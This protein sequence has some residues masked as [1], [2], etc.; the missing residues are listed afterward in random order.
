[1]EAPWSNCI[2][3]KAPQCDFHAPS[4]LICDLN[5]SPPREGN[6]PSVIDSWQF[7][8]ETADKLKE[9]N[10]QLSETIKDAPAESLARE[11]NRQGDT[12]PSAEEA[13]QNHVHLK[14]PKRKKHRPKVIVEGKSKRAK[15]T[16]AQEKAHVKESTVAKR[17]HVR[18]KGPKESATE[19]ADDAGKTSDLQN[20]AGTKSRRRALNFDLEQNVKSNATAEQEK[21][22]S[23]YLQFSSSAHA[24]TSENLTAASLIHGAT[25]TPQTHQEE[26]SDIQ[27]HPVAGQVDAPRA[28]PRPAQALPALDMVE[29]EF[30][31]VGRKDKQ[32][33]DWRGRER[34]DPLRVNSLSDLINRNVPALHTKQE[35]RQVNL[36]GEKYLNGISRYQQAL[37][38]AP[39]NFP[40]NLQARGLKRCYDQNNE[41]AFPPSQS[42]MGIPSVQQ[43][44]QITSYH[45]NNRS[46]GSECSNAMIKKNKTKKGLDT[47]TDDIPSR[48]ARVDDSSRQEIARLSYPVETRMPLPT[49]DV[50]NVSALDSIYRRVR[51]RFNSCSP[52]SYFSSNFASNKSESAASAQQQAYLQW[53]EVARRSLDVSTV[54]FAAVQTRKIQVTSGNS[55]SSR[56]KEK[57]KGQQKSLS[58]EASGPQKGSSSQMKDWNPLDQIIHQLGHLNL[59]GEGSGPE[60]NALVL[61]KEYGTI[62]PYEGLD[63]R[64]RKPRPKVDLDSETKR[65][66]N[67]L[68]GKESEGPQHDVEKEKWW[69]E[70]REVF[71]GRADSFIARMH[72]IQGDRRFSRWKGSVVDSVIGVFLTQNVSDHLSSSAFMSLIAR[73]PPGSKRNSQTPEKLNADLLIKEPV[74]HMLNPEGTLVLQDN[75]EQISSK[76]FLESWNARESAGMEKGQ[77]HSSEEEMM[78]SLESF[79]CSIT[80]GYGGVRSFSGSNSESEDIANHLKPEETCSLLGASLQK[81]KFMYGHEQSNC[82]K[83]D[84]QGLILGRVK[85]TSRYSWNSSP[86][87]SGNHAVPLSPSL[88]IESLMQLKESNVPRVQ[89]NI[90]GDESMSSW[91]TMSQS[92]DAE[93]QSKAP[94]GQGVLPGSKGKQ[95]MTD[96]QT[97]FDATICPHSSILG[98]APAISQSSLIQHFHEHENS[99]SQETSCSRNA[100]GFL[101]PIAREPDSRH[102]VSSTL[103]KRVNGCKV[104]EVDRLSHSQDTPVETNAAEGLSSLE[105]SKEIQTPAKAKRGKAVE[106]RKIDWDYLRREVQVNCEKR[107]RTKDS[108]DS[109]DY[110]ALRQ[111]SINEISD[112]IRE[113]GMNNMLAERIKG[114]LDRLVQEHGSID[115]EWLRDVSP[116]K[117]KDYLLSIRGLGLKSVECVRLLTLHN[118]AFPVDTN[119]GRIAVRLGWVPLQP[120]P[121]S[122]QL[123]LLELYPVLES[124]QKYLWP[125]LCKLD[126]P[127][128]YELHYQLITFG[129]VFCTKSRP[130]C[131]GCPMRGE[132]RHF[133]SAFTSARLALPAPEDKSLVP[134]MATPGENASSTVAT[135]MLLPPAQNQSYNTLSVTNDCQP[136]I[137]EPATPE[138]ERAV[139][140]DR[141]IEDLFVEDDDEIPTIKLNIKEFTDNLQSFMQQNNMELQE[142]DMSKALVA[143]NPEAASIPARKLKNVSRLRTEHQVYEL[144]DD[145]PLLDGLEKREEDDPSPYLLAIWTPG[146]TPN[147]VQQPQEQ[148]KLQNTGSLCNEPTC[149][150]CNSLRE[151]DSQTVRGTLLI[152]CR[153]A[154]RGSFPLNGTYFQVNE[155]FADHE[156]SIKP[157]FVPR[158]SIW[159]LRRRTVYFG[160]SVTAIFRGLSTEEVQYCFWRGFVCV[161]G[162]ERETRAPRPLVARLHFTARKEKGHDKRQDKQRKE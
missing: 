129:K 161:R 68:M 83:Y 130:N 126:Q 42:H 141:D 139:A 16:E 155:M 51:D 121:E 55:S 77:T 150:S 105:E 78:L 9:G 29:A 123:H 158:D 84:H 33:E 138:E 39:S 66:W 19:Q 21:T 101:K 119:V 86:I 82:C 114:F 3:A 53:K 134:S 31:A 124:V 6:A 54:S 48:V 137:E 109:I 72:L 27:N 43:L 11:S 58:A 146:E 15:Q 59:N 113:R 69:Q 104:P 17:K 91:L 56:S 151:A 142:A 8:P 52:E 152:P 149:S 143:L 108:M 81:E 61:Y 153:T 100:G 45:Q 12:V 75:I 102:H 160:T 112:T 103:V 147:T 154:M 87:N 23:A 46:V 14:T 24:Q 2:P 115:L 38:L 18:R 5:S 47:L 125:R 30:S 73:F 44:L 26:V 22:N 159:N 110:E 95:I 13:S 140:L 97:N 49:G 74:T 62:I 88:S 64:K 136:I 79:D 133:A 156:S 131:N 89:Y 99:T 7:I 107:E 128:L 120:L 28:E 65:I 116:D 71:R 132:C 94:V 63:L 60:N 144:P 76:I 145:H 90:L 40:C 34:R 50:Q 118:L 111:A 20:Q 92:V 96:H 98:H 93:M 162:F 85:S 70:E 35:V 127:T 36:E 80:E 4:R 57:S 122:L 106:N 1:M 148:C 67:L 135:Q 25:T 10:H 117:A 41:Q 37:E 157:L 32:P